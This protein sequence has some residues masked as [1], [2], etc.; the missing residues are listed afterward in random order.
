VYAARIGDIEVAR[1]YD[2]MLEL[3][4]LVDAAEARGECPLHPLAGEPA[5]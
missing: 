4:D 3:M 5:S 2:D 1:A